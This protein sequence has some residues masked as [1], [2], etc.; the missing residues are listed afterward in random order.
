MD[1]DASNKYK[2]PLQLT[3][4]AFSKQE[5]PLAQDSNILSSYDSS[6]V[7]DEHMAWSGDAQT[8]K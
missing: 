5:E 1:E 7:P 4:F 2:I 6:P 8:L 3:N